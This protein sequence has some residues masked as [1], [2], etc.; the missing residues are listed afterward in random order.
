MDDIEVTSA[1]TCDGD[2]SSLLLHFIQSETLQSK[3]I[4]QSLVVDTFA[5]TLWKGFFDMKHRL[6]KINN[7]D[8]EKA[9]DTGMT[10]ISHLFWILFNCSSNLQLTL[11]LTERGR[12]L[13]SEF[14]SMSRTHELMQ[15]AEVYPT[16]QDGF[17]FAIKKSIGTLTCSNASQFD[18][19]TTY[20]QY[21]AN[22]LTFEN[23]AIY[24]KI[25]RNVF[26]KINRQYLTSHDDTPWNAD[27]VN[28][29]LHKL[30]QTLT[31]AIQRTK[32]LD[33]LEHIICVELNQLELESLLSYFLCLQLVCYQPFVEFED[34]VNHAPEDAVSH[35]LSAR[36]AR[37][38][39]FVEQ[40]AHMLDTTLH[41]LS[42]TN[43]LQDK[44]K[45]TLHDMS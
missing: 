37:L 18:S 41:F 23:I 31:C 39:Q 43:G 30:N 5:C 4:S 20:P 24:R 29:S 22:R 34:T 17:Q 11:F 14:L 16:I 15:N 38:A 1:D 28:I 45:T 12:L 36:V 26:E 13:Y 35:I 42:G 25:Y 27:H 8:V 21:S 2:D 40:H 6:Y 10:L 33:I 9:V 32:S 44:W 7:L 3:Q 19:E